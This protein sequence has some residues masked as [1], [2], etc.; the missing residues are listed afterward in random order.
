M[1]MVT[2]PASLYAV[3]MPSL[4]VLRKFRYVHSLRDVCD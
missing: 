1:H 3:S 2:V 4:Y